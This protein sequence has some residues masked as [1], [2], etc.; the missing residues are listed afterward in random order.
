MKINNS[1]VRLSQGDLMLCPQCEEHRFPTVHSD[2]AAKVP[3]SASGVVSDHS[4]AASTGTRN[5]SEPVGR[6]RKEK[7]KVADADDGAASDQSSAVGNGS[8]NKSDP[9][10]RLRKE[11]EKTTDDEDL[12]RQLAELQNT[13][14]KQC[15]TI[16]KLSTQL[17][18]VLSFLDIQQKT[19]NELELSATAWPPLSAS[20]VGPRQATPEEQQNIHQTTTLAEVVSRT[21]K[22]VS[23]TSEI[24]ERRHELISA[25]Y[26]EQNDKARRAN[27]FMVSGLA[28]NTIDS[29]C[30][31]VITLCRNEFCLDLDVISTKRV[32]HSLVNKPRL[33]MV[34]VKSQ[35]QAQ[36]VIQSARQLRH[37]ADTYVKSHVY[38]NA[39]LTKAEAKAQYELRMR[40]RQSLRS[41]GPPVDDDQRF[42]RD[43]SDGRPHDATR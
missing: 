21:V 19:D 9:T 36:R 35:E 29:D 31:Q 43:S 8:K 14:T 39:N 28:E 1:T 16:Q 41:R 26:I 23:S 22:S 10:G 15:E 12:R 38:I 30:E 25:V 5:K 13:V 6:T 27:S 20:L 18:F 7:E 32:G 3:A 11:K 42:P 34:H 37:S 24:Q 17:Q 2:T 4:A 33:L 40:R